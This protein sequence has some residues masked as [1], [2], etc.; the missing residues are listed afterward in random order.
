MACFI[1]DLFGIDKNHIQPDVTVS[2]Q[3]LLRPKNSQLDTEYS[4]K[5]ISFY[6][7]M[8]FRDSIKECLENFA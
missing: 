6:P 7:R 4:F 3:T 5:L 8:K 2:A 1:A